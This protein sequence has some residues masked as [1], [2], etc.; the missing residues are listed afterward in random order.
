MVS[1]PPKGCAV[2]AVVLLIAAWFRPAGLRCLLAALTALCL[3]IVAR[4][5]IAGHYFVARP[6]AAYH[7]TPLYPHGAD[8]SFPSV[9]TSYFAA[10]IVP[11]SRTGRL[12]GWLL[13]AITAEVA[14][15][16]V[17][18]GVHYTTDVLAGAG[19]GLAA[20]LV[21]WLALGSPPAAW[22]I[23]RADRVLIR[24]RLRPQAA[25]LPG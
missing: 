14:V 15:G 9:T 2:L 3:V 6:F 20:G 4:D 21:A 11:A 19:I 16:C 23:G 18:V 12:A 10:M 17:Y 25:P 1:R 22:L 13:G 8:S 5:L 24:A 7:F